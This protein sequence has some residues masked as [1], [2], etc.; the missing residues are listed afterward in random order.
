MKLFFLFYYI[1]FF[2][3]ANDY[4]ISGNVLDSDS[5][6][7]L[8]NVNIFLENQKQIIQTDKLGYFNFLLENSEYKSI[9][10]TFR[11]IG[12]EDKTLKINLIDQKLSKNVIAV[13]I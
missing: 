13:V 6:T 11:L 10:L 5:E 8:S 9:D 4:I 3:F 12:Y 2:L 1:N 7:G